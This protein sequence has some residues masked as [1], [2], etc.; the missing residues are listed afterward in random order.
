VDSSVVLRI[1]KEGSPAARAWFD[2]ALAAGDTFLASRLM[3]AEVLRVLRNNDL[4]QAT[5]EDVISRFVLLSLDDALVA[6]AVAI[7]P[8]VGAADGLHLASAARVGVGA[9]AVVTHDRQMAR[10]AEALGFAVVDPVTDDPGRP[11]VV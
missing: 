5:A 8:V 1:V 4:S 9:V 7:G 6:E 3:V 11:A 10:A 2:R